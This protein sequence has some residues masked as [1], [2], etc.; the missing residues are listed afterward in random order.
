MDFKHF[1]EK[2]HKKSLLILWDSQYLFQLFNNALSCVFLQ[3]KF[4][5]FF[6]M[7]FCVRL[8]LWL[9][10]AY[11]IKEKYP[12]R[13]QVLK[14][15]K[16]RI[17]RTYTDYNRLYYSNKRATF[18]HYFSN[19]LLQNKWSV[20]AFDDWDFVSCSLIQEFLLL[21]ISLTYNAI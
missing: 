9:K 6:N 3:W 17:R 18:F 11:K 14:L 5:S 21:I 13:N 19:S 16:K 1:T 7:P 15:R 10:N 8:F 12:L 2:T 4:Q 20:S